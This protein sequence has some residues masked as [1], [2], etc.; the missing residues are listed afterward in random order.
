MLLLLSLTLDLGGGLD[1]LLEALLH[2]SA[3]VECV[4]DLMRSLVDNVPADEVVS[5]SSQILLLSLP[6]RVRLDLDTTGDDHKR[7]VG[8]LDVPSRRDFV[9]G[10][11]VSDKVLLEL[12]L[13][14]FARLVCV[15]AVDTV[16]TGTALEE[17]ACETDSA[18]W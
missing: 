4:P 18:N 13:D 2:D 14:V 15:A 7:S 1:E 10:K 6:L 9:L 5:E 3:S 8:A 16:F 11:T 12:R 17:R